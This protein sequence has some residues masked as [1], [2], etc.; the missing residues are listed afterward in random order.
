M[1]GILWDQLQILIFMWTHSMHWLWIY[2]MKC[3]DEDEERM[4]KIVEAKNIE[5][6]PFIDRSIYLSVENGCSVLLFIFVS[7]Y[8]VPYP[9]T[10]QCT[11]LN[12]IDLS[13]EIAVFGYCYCIFCTLAT[14]WI[15]LTLLY[16]FEIKLIE[17]I[18]MVSFSYTI[19]RAVFF[20]S[21]SKDAKII[22]I[23]WYFFF[24]KVWVY[25]PRIS[26]KVRSIE[27][28]LP[29]HKSKNHFWFRSVFLLFTSL[30][31]KWL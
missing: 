9:I 19:K 21:V 10:D 8:F 12:K 24:W 16:W 7:V 18:R 27:N 6:D 20:L 26:E 17:S 5:G 13:L 22:F 14:H 30:H 2:G 15:P 4:K 23:Y 28:A 25:R 11:W 29:S 3:N 1:N 31:Q